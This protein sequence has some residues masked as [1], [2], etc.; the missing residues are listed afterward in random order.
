MLTWI[1]T[2]VITK[3]LLGIV[4]SNCVGSYISPTSAQECNEI[5][6]NATTSCAID[7]ALADVCKVNINGPDSHALTVQCTATRSCA[8]SDASSAIINCQDATQCVI[9]CTSARLVL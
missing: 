7:C 8:S 3:Y 5:K 2:L 1:L 4:H 6:C 9:N